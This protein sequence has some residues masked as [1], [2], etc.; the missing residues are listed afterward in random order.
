[1]TSSAPSEWQN[2]AQFMRKLKGTC[3]KVKTVALKTWY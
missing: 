3:N 1:M 2:A